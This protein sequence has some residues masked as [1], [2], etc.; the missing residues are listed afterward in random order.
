MMREDKE[1]NVMVWREPA[2]ETVVMELSAGTGV[3]RG[4][5]TASQMP[6]ATCSRTSTGALG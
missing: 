6:G 1:K 4:H 3:K 2:K 5:R